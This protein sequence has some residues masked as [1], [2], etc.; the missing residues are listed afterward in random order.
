MTRISITFEQVASIAEAL[1]N[2]NKEPTVMS[3]RDRLGNRGGPCTIYKYLIAWRETYPLAELAKQ[4]ATPTNERNILSV[5]AT[6]SS[7]HKPS[8]KNQYSIVHE[9]S[10]KESHIKLQIERQARCTAEQKAVVLAARLAVLEAENNLLKDHINS[11]KQAM[12]ILKH[13][14]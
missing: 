8:I 4:V 6:R 5:D 10:G 12:I 13:R 11:L 7:K 9:L 2:E 3:V 14:K 1:I